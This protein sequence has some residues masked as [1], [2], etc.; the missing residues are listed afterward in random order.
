MK[1]REIKVQLVEETAIRPG[2]KYADTQYTC[3]DNQHVKIPAQ[4][5]NCY[6]RIVSTYNKRTTGSGKK[7]RGGQIKIR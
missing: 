3:A 5:E 4:T 6:K 7:N 1:P 2:D